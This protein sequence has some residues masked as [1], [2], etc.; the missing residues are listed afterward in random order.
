MALD[1]PYP[2]VQLNP[3]EELTPQRM[4][5]ILQAIQGNFDFLFSLFPLGL[6]GL[7]FKLDFGS[8]ELEWP[9]GSIQSNT[10]IVA[11]KLGTAPKAVI[12]NCEDSGREVGTF[13]YNAVNFSCA[14]QT[15]QGDMPAAGTKQTIHWL[16][17]AAS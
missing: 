8:A 16:A 14:L 15:L 11:H 7:A 3:R 13:S 5:D 4:A 1:P 2:S 17:V 12:G 10:Q 6:E 9:G